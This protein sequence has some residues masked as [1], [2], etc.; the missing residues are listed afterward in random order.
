MLL[1]YKIYIAVSMS[2]V[3]YISSVLV[4]VLVLR[5]TA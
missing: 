2:Y 3:F 5:S 4:S 1:I